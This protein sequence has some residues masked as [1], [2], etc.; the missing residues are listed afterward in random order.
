MRGDLTLHAAF[1]VLLSLLA[2]EAA[3]APGVDAKAKAQ[4]LLNEGAQHY[5]QA[6]FAAALAKFEQAYALFPSPRLLF[7]IGQASRELGRP[8]EAIHAFEGFL[9]QVSEAP[10][11]M[12]DEAKR[13]VAELST[14]IGKLLIECP[15]VGAVINVDGKKVGEAPIKDLIRVAP[16]RHQVTATHPSALP[17]IED[18]TVAVGTVQTV[19]L[20]PLALAEAPPSA[21]PEVVPGLDVR[22]GPPSE[23]PVADD[24]WWL[25]R[26]WT[27]VAAG[28]AVVLAGGAA[29][30]GRAMQSKFDELDQKCGSS[31]GVN[32]TGCSDS[33]ISALDLRKNAAN[34]LWG[35][36]AAAVM[37]AGVL[38][39]VEG[40]PVTVAPM[41]GTMTGV[42]AST[43]F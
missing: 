39:F 33:D 21:E 16:G 11:E 40:R 23:A 19:V 37:T 42:L 34:V 27:W 4:V 12:F 2:Q 10:V 26:K 7:N 14:Q 22:A 30:A 29:I 15:L 43:W 1:F 38:F 28:S 8:V 36:S 32:Y 25:G 20:R 41:A 17:A 5:E 3:P 24:G 18:V 35:L 31:A 6:E 13:S 9:A